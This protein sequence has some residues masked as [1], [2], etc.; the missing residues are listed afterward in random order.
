MCDLCQL[1]SNG[2]PTVPIC[3]RYACRR[4]VAIDA[5]RCDNDRVNSTPSKLVSTSTAARELGVATSTLSRWAAAGVITP[6]RRTVGGHMR[7]DLDDLREQL[8]Q[9][10]A[11]P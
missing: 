7:W 4:L 9:R 5:W 11:K 2:K 10:G 3:A 6:A 1:L 8:T